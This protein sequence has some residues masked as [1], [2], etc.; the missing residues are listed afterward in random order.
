MVAYIVLVGREAA[1]DMGVMR[2]YIEQ[3]ESVLALYGGKYRS[4]GRHRVTELEGSLGPLR[5]VTIIEFPNPEQA[6][7]W[8]DSPEYAPLKELRL[9]N[10]RFDV[11]LVEGLRDDEPATLPETR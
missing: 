5:G 2:P 1:K 3:A 9:A 8:Y 6:R 11:I 7:A 4:R 10:L